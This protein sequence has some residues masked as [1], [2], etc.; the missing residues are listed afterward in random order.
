MKQQKPDRTIRLK[1]LGEEPIART[2]PRL[3]WR[4][5]ACR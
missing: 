4:S 5:T 2:L 3:V 1:K